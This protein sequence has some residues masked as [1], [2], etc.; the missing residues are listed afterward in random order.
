M[1]VRFASHIKGAVLVCSGWTGRHGVK[2][3]GDR[4]DVVQSKP[5][6]ARISVA[7]L[8]WTLVKRRRKPL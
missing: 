8:P 1:R 6:Q 3:T 2:K 7:T 5:R 4:Y